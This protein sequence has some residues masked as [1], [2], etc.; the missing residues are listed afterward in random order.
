M[1][2]LVSVLFAGYGGY[3]LGEIIDKRCEQKYGPGWPLPVARIIIPIGCVSLTILSCIDV[4]VYTHAIDYNNGYQAGY[5]TGFQD[6][7]PI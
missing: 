4:K 6:D 1:G 2:I 5:A 3:K 7:R